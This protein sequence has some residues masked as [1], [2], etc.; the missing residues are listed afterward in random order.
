M[1][2]YFKYPRTFHL[3]WSPGVNRDDQILVSVD[4]FRGQQVIVTEKLDGENTSMYSD[5][6]HARSLDSR[7]HPSRA[8]VK[9]LHGGIKHEIPSGWRI[10]GENL[11]A[12][13][14]I[15]YRGLPTYFFVFAVYDATNTCLSWDEATRHAA[16][17]GLQ[18]I[19]VLYRGPWDEDAVKACWTGRSVFDA[20]QEGY[21]V[22]IAK[23]FSYD[24]QHPGGFSRFAAKY[25][26]AG[27]VRTDDHWLRAPLVPNL[28]K[29]DS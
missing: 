27:H 29:T 23:A 16:M 9:T 3:P 1:N 12:R 17:L 2:A 15:H 21:V 6:F 19:P 28:L 8:W 25:V 20:E 18:T 4:Y 11:Y 10:C 26:R 5:H 7:H 13:H 22:R 24:D 14:S